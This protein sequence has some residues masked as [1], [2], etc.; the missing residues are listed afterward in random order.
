M[1]IRDRG[2]DKAPDAKLFADLAKD[3]DLRSDIRY[4]PIMFFREVFLQNLSLENFL[5]SK[6][7]IGTRKLERHFGL[8]LALRP[9]QT[10]Q[11]HWVPLPEKTSRVSSTT[12]GGAASRAWENA[13]SIS[14]DTSASI[15]SSSASAVIPSSTKRRR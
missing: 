5:D 7:T 14:A 1:C 3:E 11:P 6:H 12:S 9:N 13:S 10:S 15:R 4:Q 2:G 8:K